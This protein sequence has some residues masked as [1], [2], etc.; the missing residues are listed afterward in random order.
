MSFIPLFI[1]NIYIAPFQDYYS[2][3][4]STPGRLRGAFFR[5]A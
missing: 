2:E 1:T 5:W 3:A 4:L